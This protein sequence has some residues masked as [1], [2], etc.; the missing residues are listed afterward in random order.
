MVRFVLALLAI[1]TGL[2][3][4][5]EPAQARISGFDGVQLEAA[6]DR[7]AACEVRQLDQ[8]IAPLE[9]SSRERAQTS[10]CPHPVLT[11]VIPTVQLGP[12]RAHE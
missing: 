6:R 4:V 5:G 7:G 10:V 2:A 11:I 3:A 1:L 9:L 8:S 12:D